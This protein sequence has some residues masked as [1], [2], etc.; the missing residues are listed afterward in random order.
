MGFA[1]AAALA[2]SVEVEKVKAA[3]AAAEAVAMTRLPEPLPAPVLEATTTDAAEAAAE[4]AQLEALFAMFDLDEEE[5]ADP[6]YFPEVADWAQKN[7][8]AV[9]TVLHDL[10]RRLGYFVRV[11]RKYGIVPGSLVM[12]QAD[13]LGSMNAATVVF[14]AIQE[15]VGKAAETPGSPLSDAVNDDGFP[16]T[17]IVL[18]KI[19]PHPG[20]GA[21]PESAPRGGK[22]TAILAE[23]TDGSR[24]ASR[25]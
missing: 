20:H 23:L 4:I 15:M 17:P 19:Y 21:H 25:I 1:D 5:A 22:K 2:A 16:L 12:H 6:V 13:V 24:T 3:E 18:E 7:A 10:E 9:R 14:A 11:L 8:D